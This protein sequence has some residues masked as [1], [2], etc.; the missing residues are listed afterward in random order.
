ML[1]EFRTG[2]NHFEMGDQQRLPRGDRIWAAFEG[3]VGLE[4]TEEKCRAEH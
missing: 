4:I 1:E 2:R 3:C